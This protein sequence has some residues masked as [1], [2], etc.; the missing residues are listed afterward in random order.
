MRALTFL[1]IALA[2]FVSAAYTAPVFFELALLRFHV[3]PWLCIVFADLPGCLL[4]GS[5]GFPRT[6][7]GVYL[8][9][10][11]LETKLLSSQVLPVSTVV[12]VSNILP[13]LIIAALIVRM[14]LIMS[15]NGN[16]FSRF[17]SRQNPLN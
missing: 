2:V 16:S 9:A 13:T 4:L 10:T 11:V 7:V 8:G 1:L 6:A 15:D 17:F 14:V 3:T 12:W 5:L